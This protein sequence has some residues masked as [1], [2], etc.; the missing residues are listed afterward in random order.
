MWVD[1]YGFEIFMGDQE[2]RKEGDRWIPDEDDK[3][4]MLPEEFMKE[5][6]G[7]KVI[8]EHREKENKLKNTG[9]F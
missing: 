9:L 1:K 3:V 5:H 4:T 2:K 6:S 8:A 7:A